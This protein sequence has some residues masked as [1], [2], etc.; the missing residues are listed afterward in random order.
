MSSAL[1]P[2]TDEALPR[3]TA[4]V[5]DLRKQDAA[6]PLDMHVQFAAELLQHHGKMRFRATYLSFV[7]ALAVA[8]VLFEQT[9]PEITAIWAAGTAFILGCDMLLRSLITKAKRRWNIWATFCNISLLAQGASFSAALTLLPITDLP[10]LQIGALAIAATLLAANTVLHAN[11]LRLG[12]L[13]IFVPLVAAM[14][15]HW[16]VLA[17]PLLTSSIALSATAGIQGLA[18][19]S[20]HVRLARL[21]IEQERHTL[22]EELAYADS[23]FEAAQRL[24]D[25][26]NLSKS[27]FMATMSHELRTPLNAIIG[28]SE[29]MSREVLGPMGNSKYRDYAE[30][31]H[32]SGTHLLGMIDGVLDLSRLESGRYALEEEPIKISELIEEIVRG[33]K[34]SAREKDLALIVQVQDN[35]PDLQA[36]ER[37]VRQIVMNLLSNAIKFTP[38]NGSISVTAGWTRSGGQYIAVRDTGPGI[39]E[40]EINAVL[41]PF[42]QGELA[43]RAATP[44]TGLGLPL[45]RAFMKL[46]DGAFLLKPAADQ[47]THAVAIFPPSRV[48]P[49][50]VDTPEAPADTRI[51]QVA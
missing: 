34:N 16:A 32:N 11:S 30:D 15:T 1:G 9:A 21:S 28:F 25:Q 36:D 31:I 50:K 2:L 38:D 48:I 14:A 26:A 3:G 45:V 51:A 42:S 37:A 47:G 27:R 39:C 41:A 8:W 23:K 17:W 6:P 44:G 29:M 24:A 4:K 35:L 43:N 13:A 33:A 22:M 12:A 20:R 49:N 46:H 5:R 7:A 10:S 19:L 18:A 40:N